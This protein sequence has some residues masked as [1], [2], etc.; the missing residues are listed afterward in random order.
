M[1]TC[2]DIGLVLPNTE[3]VEEEYM[4]TELSTGSP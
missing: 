4:L 1:V 3:S 2:S